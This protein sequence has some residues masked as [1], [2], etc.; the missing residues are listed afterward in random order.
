MKNIEGFLSENFQFL[1]MKFSMY[2]NRRVFVMGL[3]ARQPEILHTFT[4]N[5]IHFLKRSIRQRVGCVNI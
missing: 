1:E 5:K 3:F 2:W 4:D